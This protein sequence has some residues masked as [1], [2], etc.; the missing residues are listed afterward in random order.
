[1]Y[2]LLGDIVIDTDELIEKFA[3]HQIKVIENVTNAAKRDDAVAFRIAAPLEELGGSGTVLDEERMDQLMQKAEMLYAEKI[4]P[5]LEESLSYRLYAYHYNEVEDA[6]I[7]N[8]VIMD[9]EIGRR[10]LDDVIKR[11]LDV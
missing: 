5:H 10:K 6:V 8:L 2:R 9:R 11:L 1:M 4:R 7:L 3:E